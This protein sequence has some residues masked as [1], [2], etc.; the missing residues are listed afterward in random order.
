MTN[1]R[2]WHYNQHRCSV[3]GLPFQSAEQGWL[4]EVKGHTLSFRVPEFATDEAKIELEKNE[5]WLDDVVLLCDPDDEM[6][7]LIPSF[8]YENLSNHGFQH[9]SR[10]PS[11]SPP[12]IMKSSAIEE[13]EALHTGGPLFHLVEPGG[14]K[15]EVNIHHMDFPTFDKRAY[16][17]IHSNCLTI[18]KKVLAS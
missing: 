6:G 8:K 5:R 11:S 7:Q 9:T 2:A 18:A 3:C 17:P 13:H 16:I 14:E 12:T 4:L 1:S 10:F 15:R